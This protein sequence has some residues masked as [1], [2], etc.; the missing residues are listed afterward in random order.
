MLHIHRYLYNIYTNC[1]N[2][3]SL[4]HLFLLSM[5]KSKSRLPFVYEKQDSTYGNL[6]NL[7]SFYQCTIMHLCI[8]V[9]I[10]VYVDMLICLIVNNVFSM[11]NHQN[12][13]EK[14]DVYSY[15]HSVK[16]HVLY[17]KICK[18]KQ[19]ITTEYVCLYMF[20]EYAFTH[21]NKG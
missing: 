14:M 15:Q 20:T 6:N 1:T 18:R 12:L 19:F 11:N 8:Y 13:W 21:L 16:S 3:L 2:F 10:Y 17:S 5:N 7:L 4:L 9:Y